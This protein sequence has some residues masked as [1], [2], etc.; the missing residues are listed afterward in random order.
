MF[1]LANPVFTGL[2]A[3]G[4][5]KRTVKPNQKSLVSKINSKN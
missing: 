3:R 5:Q 1:P 2:S 4:Y